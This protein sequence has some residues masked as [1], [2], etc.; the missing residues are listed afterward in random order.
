M[1]LDPV[2]LSQTLDEAVCILVDVVDELYRGS[3]VKVLKRVVDKK[4]YMLARLLFDHYARRLQQVLERSPQTF[5]L[6]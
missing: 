5:K 4:C 6:H 3:M 1:L 2:G